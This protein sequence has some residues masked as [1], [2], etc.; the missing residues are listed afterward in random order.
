MVKPKP[1]RAETAAAP[2]PLATDSICSPA[3]VRRWGKMIPR[4][5]PPAPMQPTRNLSL[6]RGCGAC[7]GKGDFAMGSALAGA[8]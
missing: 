3:A 8:W 1:A 7:G 2:V 5:N 6:N 4:A